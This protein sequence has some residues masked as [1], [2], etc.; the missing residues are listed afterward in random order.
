ML[1]EVNLLPD[2]E[3]EHSIVPIILLVFTMIIL[4]AYVLFGFYYVKTKS[5]LQTV[6]EQSSNMSGEVEILRAQAEELT[7]EASSSIE[8]AVSFAENYNIPTSELIIEINDLLPEQGYLK[9]YVYEE[10]V[11]RPTIHVETLDE[12]AN[13]TTALLASDFIRDTKVNRAEAFTVKDE[14]LTET[15]VEFDTIP[16][17]QADFTL[18]I[19]KE[20]LKGAN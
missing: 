10:K 3:R 1:P 19:H 11:V 13:Y 2:Y 9:E 14:G 16:R 20:K 17:F 12:V 4:L 15:A 18:D 8:Q 6:E 7:T 5:N